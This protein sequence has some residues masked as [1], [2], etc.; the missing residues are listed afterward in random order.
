LLAFLL[1]PRLDLLRRAEPARFGLR[2]RR[3]LQFDLVAQ[4]IERAC[5]RDTGLGLRNLRLVVGGSICT[6]RSPALTRWNHSRRS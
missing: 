4:I 2:D 5:A 3:V 6:S 1:L